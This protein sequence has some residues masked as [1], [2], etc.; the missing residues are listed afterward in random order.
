MWGFFIFIK[1][2]I[3]VFMGEIVDYSKLRLDVLEK[4]IYQRGIDCK[5]K[6]DEMIRMLKLY[7]EGKYVE[8]ML[9]TTYDKYESG[10][11]IGIDLRNHTQLVQIGK[12]VEKR[13]AKRLNRYASGRVYYWG[14]NKLI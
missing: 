4:I 8:P 1:L 12:L 10:F 5:L 13:E 11:T 2:R 14:P 7:D 6:K 3:F 9:E